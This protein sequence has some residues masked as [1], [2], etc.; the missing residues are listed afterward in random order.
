M[1]LKHAGYWNTGLLSKLVNLQHVADLGISCLLQLSALLRILFSEDIG[2]TLRTSRNWL[3][4]PFL[5]GNHPISHL[6]NNSN[7]PHTVLG[8]Y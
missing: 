1:R 4:F 2:S 7:M 8:G 3:L 6:M 5:L